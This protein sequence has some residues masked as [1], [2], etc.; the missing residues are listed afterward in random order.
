MEIVLFSIF[1]SFLVE[2][3]KHPIVVSITA[4][5]VISALRSD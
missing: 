4:L 3:F 5:F 1:L 2:F